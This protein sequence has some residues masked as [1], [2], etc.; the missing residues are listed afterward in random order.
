[1]RNLKKVQL[2]TNFLTTIMNEDE[3][4]NGQPQPATDQNAQKPLTDTQNIPVQDGMIPQDSSAITDEQNTSADALGVQSID[5]TFASGNYAQIA[6]LPQLVT[7]KVQA[8]TNTFVPLV[9][10]SLIELTGSSQQY[11]RKF[12]QV[13]PSFDQN[14]QL[15]LEFNIQ[16]EV[17]GYIGTEFE[18]AD[19]QA[20][21]SYIYDRIKPAGIQVT[22]CEIDT[23]NGIVTIMGSV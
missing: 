14:S 8:L 13:T 10:V 11:K 22:K 9:E 6:S 18:Y 5:V 17:P 19:L 4:E 23:S 3:L 20:D 15:M 12:A 16:Y 7:Q 1:M 2:T 21:S